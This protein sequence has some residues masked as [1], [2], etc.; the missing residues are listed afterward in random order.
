MNTYEFIL[1]VY[2]N[3]PHPLAC[4]YFFGAVN[5]IKDEYHWIVRV[6]KDFRLCLESVLYKIM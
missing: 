4:N 2:I 6:V 1:F 5:V 3:V